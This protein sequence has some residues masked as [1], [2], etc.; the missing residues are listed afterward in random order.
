MLA[1]SPGSARGERRREQSSE[2]ASAAPG[3][4]GGRAHLSR[5]A[6]RHLSR[7]HP[8][9]AG[10]PCSPVSGQTGC[11]AGTLCL[12]GLA[13]RPH[14]VLILPTLRLVVPRP[15]PSPACAAKERG[16]FKSLVSSAILAWKASLWCKAAS[17]LILLPEV[18]ESVLALG[19]AG[20]DRSAV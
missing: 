11:V 6:G 3:S 15:W 1:S 12:L 18:H 9:A 17:G 19:R 10:P 8:P 14:T 16:P 7:A 2:V 5:E 20:A 4:A 13:L